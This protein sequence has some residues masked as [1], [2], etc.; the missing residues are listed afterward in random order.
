[1]YNKY[2]FKALKIMS[3]LQKELNVDFEIKNK[4]RSILNSLKLRNND[5]S[6]EVQLSDDIR[7]EIENFIND[8]DI[9]KLENK[10]IDIL[11][12]NEL[13]NPDLITLKDM[14]D[15]EILCFLYKILSGVSYVQKGNLLLL[16]YNNS[17]WHIGWN[18]FYISCRGKIID[19]E[20]EEIISYPFDKFF[21]INEVEESKVERIEALIK[22]SKYLYLLD[23]VDGSTISITKNKNELLVTTNGSFEN[24]QIVYAKK[25]IEE[26]YMYFKENI[27]DNY[28]YIFEIIYPKDKKVV[29]YGNDEKLI[30]LAVRDI[31]SG[32]LLRYDECLD[33]A[34]K[35]KIEP[36]RNFKYTS[37]DDLI[38]NAKNMKDANKEGWI[39]RIITDTE[40]IIVKIKL[41]EYL[42]LHKCLASEI[43]PYNIYDL[44]IND[45]LDD[46]LA[47][48]DKPVKDGISKVVNKVVAVI[49]EIEDDLINNL[50][51]AKELFGMSQE[52]FAQVF[53]DKNHE[54]YTVCI[55]LMKHIQK[56]CN[57]YY[58]KTGMIKYYV[59]GKSIEEIIKNIDVNTFKK[60]CKKQNIEF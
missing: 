29:D 56:N 23:K 49:N 47:K 30:L 10:I 38:Y 34:L 35:L 57:S 55:E 19:I 24:E 22:K 6:L 41:D 27:L 52:E 31:N 14:S 53:L 9:N 4:Y 7:I 33:V 15:R 11:Q 28:T 5:L 2:I 20:K 21:N 36:V 42:K 25:L 12:G 17:I 43:N 51:K 58:T 40:D 26:K 54:K 32:V 60:I 45:K 13:L 1:M 39:L 16:K 18:K 59:D 50:N 37:L 48:S 8:I 46:I 3:L 44:F